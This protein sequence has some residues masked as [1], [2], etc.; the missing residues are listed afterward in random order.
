MKR[1]ILAVALIS[2]IVL[3]ASNITTHNNKLRFKEIEVKDTQLKLKQLEQR[4]DVELK[5]NTVDQK[6]VEELQKEKE[7]LQ[8]QLSAKQE[9]KRIADAEA[10]RAAESL[11][12]AVTQTQTVYAA[13]TPHAGSYT[14]SGDANLDWIIQHESGGN[15]YAMNASGACGLG[16]SLPCSKVLNACGSL[17][18]VGCQIEWVRNYCVSRYG[19]TANAKSF[20]VANRWY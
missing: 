9:A 2:F 20:W 14:G 1:L 4:Y 11:A 7:E 18:N 6:K 19:S 17:D 8:K 15:P 3:G 12:N 16:Q 10:Q 13:T 5:Q